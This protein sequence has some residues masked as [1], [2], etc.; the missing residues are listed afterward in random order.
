MQELWWAA[1]GILKFYELLYSPIVE[2]SSLK[3]S[4]YVNQE[5]LW[6]EKKKSFPEEKLNASSLTL[7]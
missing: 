3:T 4:W 1:H 5:I 2:T 7:A 6:L